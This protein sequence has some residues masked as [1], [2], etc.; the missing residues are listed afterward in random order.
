MRRTLHRLS[1]RRLFGWLI[2]TAAMAFVCVM[3]AVRDYRY[4]GDIV[5]DAGYA[6]GMHTARTLHRPVLLYFH[7]ATCDWCRKMDIETFTDPGVVTQAHGYVCIRI[8][9]LRAT[10]LT[11]KYGVTELPTAIITDAEGTSLVKRT[12]FLDTQAMLELLKQST[13]AGH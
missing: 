3:G 8:D 7:A 1:R 11:R 12:G 9:Q 5:W 6:D 4:S 10:D 13:S 2:M